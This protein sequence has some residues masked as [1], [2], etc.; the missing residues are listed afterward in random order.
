MDFDT[1]L[2]GFPNSDAA[3]LYP[4]TDYMLHL[5]KASCQGRDILSTGFLRYLI[6][7]VISSEYQKPV[8]EARAR[9]SLRLSRRRPVSTCEPLLQDQTA[10]P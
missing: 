7:P 6:R 2:H 4:S 8:A 3:K 5:V 1:L 9:L 10:R